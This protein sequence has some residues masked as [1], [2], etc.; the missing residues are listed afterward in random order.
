M[1]TFRRLG[2]TENNT[3]RTVAA[4]K[5]SDREWYS[6]NENDCELFVSEDDRLFKFQ[7]IHYGYSDADTTAVVIKDELTPSELK[8]IRELYANELAKEPTW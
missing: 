6:D 7:Y 8:G 4:L 3:Y 5:K 2:D 1:I